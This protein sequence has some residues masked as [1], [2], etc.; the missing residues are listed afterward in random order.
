MSRP[1]HANTLCRPWALA[2][3]LWLAVLGPLAPTLS[4]AIVWARGDIRPLVEVCTLAGPRWVAL[5][6]AQDA[7]LEAAGSTKFQTDTP[8]GPVSALALDHCPFCLLFTDRAAPP[9]H[10]LVHLFA[11]LGESVEPTVRQVFFFPEQAM[12]AAHPRGPPHTSCTT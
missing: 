3:A 5:A 7:R 4:H 9:P 6:S 12:L 1:T 11:V 8:D 10:F 2:L